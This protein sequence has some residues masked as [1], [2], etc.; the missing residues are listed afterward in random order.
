[1][2][3]G[4]VITIVFSRIVVRLALDA[5]V[6]VSVVCGLCGDLGAFSRTYV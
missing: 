3:A 1:M 2:S 4:T 6:A 5:V